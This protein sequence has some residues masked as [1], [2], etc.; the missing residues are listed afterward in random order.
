MNVIESAQNYEEETFPRI[1]ST[2]KGIDLNE[3]GTIDS[4]PFGQRNWTGVWKHR[5]RDRG[6]DENKLGAKPLPENI[7][8]G[9]SLSEYPMV[10]TEFD[11]HPAIEVSWLV[12]G[13]EG[14]SK[15]LYFGN[16]P[17]QLL[18]FVEIPDGNIWDT[19]QPD[20]GRSFVRGGVYGSRENAWEDYA[21]ALDDSPLKGSEILPEYNHPLF[22]L[23]D[24]ITS[25]DTTW[26]LVAPLLDADYD[27]TDFDLSDSSTWE[28]SLRAEP[29]KVRKT[30][31][32]TETEG[33]DESEF[34][35]YAYWVGDEGVKSK[36]NIQN[37]NKDSSNEQIKKDNL[38]VATEPNLPYSH[39]EGSG[40]NTLKSG[41]GFGWQDPTTEAK[42]KDIHSLGLLSDL[43]SEDKDTEAFFHSVTTDSFGVLSDVRTGGLK[44]DLSSAF[45]NEDDW[46]NLENV[47]D[48]W[49]DDFSNYIYKQRIFY[50]KSVPL[51]FNAKENDW[52]TG[53]D[54]TLL[55]EHGILAGPRWSVMGSFHNLYLSSTYS[56]LTPNNFPRVV[57]D[58]NVLFN[59]LLPSGVK[60]NSPGNSSAISSSTRLRQNFNYFRGLE[61]RP[62]PTNHSLQPVLLEIKYSHHPI[63]QQGQ[64][65]LAAYPSVAFWNPYNKP[66][67]LQDIYIEIPMSIGIHAMNARHYDLYRKWWLYCY[68][69]ELFA[70]Q[71]PGTDPTEPTF[72]IPSGFKNFEDRNGNGRRDPGEPLIDASINTGNPVARPMPRENFFRYLNFSSGHPYPRSTVKMPL[73]YGGFV[74]NL[75]GN[76]INSNFTHSLDHGSTA[77]PSSGDRHLLLRI[78]ELELEPGEKAHFTVN[79]TTT[80]TPGQLPAVGQTDYIKVDLNKLT[81][82]EEDTPVV[83]LSGDSTLPGSE[84]VSVRYWSWGFRGVHPNDKEAFDANGQRIQ[85]STLKPPKGITVYFEDP[86]GTSLDSRKVLAKINKQ[87][88]LDLGSGITDFVSCDDLILPSGSNL[89]GCGFRIRFKLPAKT[90]SVVFEQFNIRALVNSNQD[91]FG[92]NWEFDSFNSNNAYG[93]ISTLFI[94]QGENSFTVGANP[95]ELSERYPNFFLFLPLTMIMYLVLRILHPYPLIHYWWALIPIMVLCRRQVLLTLQLV[96]SMMMILSA[97]WKVKNVQ[98]CLRFLSLP[99]FPFS[100]FGM[101]I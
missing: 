58:N 18:E 63:F 60:P 38:T 47:S 36:I 75:L 20:N 67:I 62:E 25:E 68:D 15:K 61:K 79:S 44:R 14:F 46:G 5:G 92:D 2:T 81:S 11:P 17:N 50:Q 73:T 55:E 83:F 6:V 48:A 27:N 89:P 98:L 99:C 23:P 10:S 30:R 12:S 94:G 7:D 93:N 95:Y 88:P 39:G 13:N 31:I 70:T 52:R 1:P 24:P 28:N 40:S 32:Q 85:N 33:S 97:V 69:P 78:S 49:K 26:L 43:I 65:G 77:A 56:N 66:I 16:N 64:L 41:L 71:N 87:F 53:S 91:G 80:I 42:K 100:S 21:S 9:D 34:G 37:P 57:G 45:A 3:N 19:D 29:V 76:V 84:P 54:Q 86:D 8:T 22:E 74:G 96:I 35:A 51:G 82:G 59:H 101:P 90:E 4:L 72:Q